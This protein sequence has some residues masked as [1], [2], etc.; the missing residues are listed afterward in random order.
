MSDS[1]LWSQE[2]EV[3]PSSH[4]DNPGK[5]GWTWRQSPAANF[6]QLDLNS[7]GSTIL[8][9]RATSWGL[10]I[11]RLTQ[12]KPNVQTIPAPSSLGAS[13]RTSE[14]QGTRHPSRNEASHPRARKAE[15]DK[16]HHGRQKHLSFNQQG[17]NTEATFLPQ[18]PGE[19]RRGGHHEEHR[20]TIKTL[21]HVV[22]TI[23][24][25]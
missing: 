8:Q 6:I 5:Q 18:T 3:A 16:D 10:S 21:V 20:T 2:R 25:K 15:W 4:I 11:Q 13:S 14:P 24:K 1:L 7:K 23:K 19:R 22:S 9:N 17:A 12:G